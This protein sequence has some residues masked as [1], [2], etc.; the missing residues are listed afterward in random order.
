MIKELTGYFWRKIKNMNQSGCQK[1]VEL[2]FNI[3]QDRKNFFLDE[4]Q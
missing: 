3:L 4:G 1:K 2:K